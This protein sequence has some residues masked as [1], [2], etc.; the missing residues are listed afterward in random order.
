MATIRLALAAA[1]RDHTV[2]RDDAGLQRGIDVL[3]G[4]NAG[5]DPLDRPVVLTHGHHSI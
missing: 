4:D 5:C 2:N 1:D 3:P